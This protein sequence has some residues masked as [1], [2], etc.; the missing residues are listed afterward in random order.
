MK[1]INL[2]IWDQMDILRDGNTTDEDYMKLCRECI[3]SNDIR[4]VLKIK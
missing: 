3:H 2:L 4:F 1:N